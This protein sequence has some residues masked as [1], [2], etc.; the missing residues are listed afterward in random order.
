MEKIESIISFIQRA[1]KPKINNVLHIYIYVYILK[2]LSKGM[3]NIKFRRA[4]SSG[5]EPWRRSGR[6]AHKFQ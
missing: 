3:N 1:K 5:G 6:G 4:V 2:I